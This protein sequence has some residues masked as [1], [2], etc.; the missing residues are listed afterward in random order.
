[1]KRVA[2]ACGGTG[3]HLYPGLAVAGELAGRGHEVMLFVS[4]KPVD[5]AVLREYPQY[6]CEALA[7]RGWPGVGRG[8][9]G[10]LLGGV[11][12]LRQA[13]AALGRFRAD[14]VLGMGGFTCAPPLWVAR[15]MRLPA[16]LHESNA[17]PGRATR[18]LAR[19]VD[20]VL[21]GF[22]SCAA[23]LPGAETR[24]TGTPVR[25]G[26]NRMDR[27]AA[28]TSWGL[29]PGRPVLAV[30]G[31]SQGAE[32]LNRLVG[33]AL[34]HAG[35]RGWQVVHLTGPGRAEPCRELYRGL[36]VNAAVEEFSPDVA[37]VLGAA[38][39][40]VARAGAS[41]LAEVSWLGLPSVLVPYPHAADD[42]QTANAREFEQAGAAR[43]LPEG[44][45]AGEQLGRWLESWLAEGRELGRMGAAA[46]GLGRRDAAARVAQE[47]LD[48][49]G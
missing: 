18:W 9:P 48:A 7:L 4:R 28:R 16:L 21:L 30:I 14:A 38:E 47:V 39:L 32:G 37:R 36:G 43:L 49:A 17:V 15:R 22:A 27:A 34:R 29:D 20:R 6:A 12:S 19:G 42:H 23:L 33:D 5:R 26:L 10:F 45:G 46:A 35:A 2:I 11:W 44:P 3:G 1:V 41:T 31:G 8:L 40:V 13:A 24:V 25:P